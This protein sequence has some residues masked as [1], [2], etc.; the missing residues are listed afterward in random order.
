M[1]SKKVTVKIK[2]FKLTLTGILRKN[3]LKHVFKKI[4]IILIFKHSRKLRMRIAGNFNYY[5]LWNQLNF[6]STGSSH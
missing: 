6:Y 2:N 4:E 1:F 3:T 5:I